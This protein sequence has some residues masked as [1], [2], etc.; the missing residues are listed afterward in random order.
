MG[1]TISWLW[2]MPSTSVFP[3]FAK[4]VAVTT[5][6]SNKVILGAGPNANFS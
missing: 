1:A 6:D 4:N 3:F 2:S 5:L